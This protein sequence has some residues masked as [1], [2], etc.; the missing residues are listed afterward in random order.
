MTSR[1]IENN[2]M[3]RLVGLAAV[4]A[5]GLLFAL[6]NTVLAQ[7]PE[8]E[9]V[10]PELILSNATIYYNTATDKVNNQGSGDPTNDFLEA[11]RYFNDYMAAMPEMTV[12]DSVGY[13]FKIADSYDQIS[14]YAAAN[15][16]EPMWDK[17]LEYFQWLIDNNPSDQD[18][19]YNNFRAGWATVQ[20]QGYAAAMP[21]FETYLELVPDD[22]LNFMWV[23]RIYLSLSNNMR[24]CDLFLHVLEHDASYADSVGPV[25]NEILNLRNK[26]SLRY[27]EITLKLI[28]HVPDAPGYFL[29]MARHKLNQARFDEHLDYVNQYL[30]VR[31]D[32]VFAIRLLG[33]E[34]RRRGDWDEAVS[35]YRR[36]L[37]IEPQRIE[38]ICDIADVY[39]QQQ[40]IM[41]AIR[42]AQR[43][44]AIDADHPYANRV[45][46]DAAIPWALNKYEE[47]YPGKEL[48]EM[49]YDFRTLMKRISDDY[50]EKAKNDPQFRAHA[51]G[52]ISYLSQ[53]F[54]QPSDRFMWGDKP[55]EITFPPPRSN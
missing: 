38:S 1:A 45:M 9:T 2:V 6:P 14:K 46:G 39:Y 31:D 54:P 50:Y 20:L 3:K 53:F 55:Y 47:T 21:Y 32:D 26:L 12:E 18:N 42:E 27:E 52:Q 34:H 35:A 28:E 25:R 5:A 49:Q 40:R 22:Y 51:N 16:S 4:V 19:A 8:Q 13:Q 30:A 48:E 29:D 10:R 44:L 24:A 17:V 15:G 7:D 23:G 11:I 36:I 41:E 33:T 37:A 43:A